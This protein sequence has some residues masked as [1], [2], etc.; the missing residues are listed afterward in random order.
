MSFRNTIA[1][2]LAAGLFATTAL[3]HDGVKITDAYAITSGANASSGAI[4]MQIEN[5]SEKDDRLIGTASDVAARVELHEHVALADGV[6]KMQE[7]AGGIFLP[8][9]ETVGLK[10]GGY[11][12]MLMGLSRLLV[13]GER[14]DLTL[15]FENAGE[16]TISVPLGPRHAGAGMMHEGQKHDA[17][18]HGAMGEDGTLKMGN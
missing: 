5:H 18:G 17:M 9:E 16:V 13:E 14:F 2:A 11:H 1:A 15:T 4:F 12:V 7:V 3:A 8:A 6:M 10:R